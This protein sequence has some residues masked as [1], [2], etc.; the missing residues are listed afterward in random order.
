MT[1]AL[2]SARQHA[3]GKRNSRRERVTVP[4]TTLE[5][6]PQ[7]LLQTILDD[8]PEDSIML[9]KL[10]NHAMYNRIGKVF[11][12]KSM[13]KDFHTTYERE[14]HKLAL[15]TRACHSC[16]RVLPISEF[17]DDQHNSKN[18]PQACCFRC[19]VNQGKHEFGGNFVIR[20]VFTWVCH[21]APNPNLIG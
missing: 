9:L 2:S 1:L 6:L 19:M 18:S 21:G 10:S 16:F 3:E 7:E 12:T 15:T 20:G 13:W 14:Q 11:Y 5:S 4:K 17:T 8:L